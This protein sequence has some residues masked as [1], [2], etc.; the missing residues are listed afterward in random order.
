MLQSGVYEQRSCLFGCSTIR[1]GGG[2]KGALGSVGSKLII[3]WI[4]PNNLDV[5][6]V[7]GQQN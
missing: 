3:V 5:C 4:S 2:P 1:E 6:T 7:P